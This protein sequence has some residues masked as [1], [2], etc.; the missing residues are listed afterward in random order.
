[1]SVCRLTEKFSAQ[2]CGV[3]TGQVLVGDCLAPNSY[4]RREKLLMMSQLYHCEKPG[5]HF[6]VGWFVSSYTFTFWQSDFNTNITTEWRAVTLWRWDHFTPR[7]AQGKTSPA[8]E[9]SD[10]RTDT[11]YWPVPLPHR[12]IRFYHFSLSECRGWA[13]SGGWSSPAQTAGRCWGATSGSRSCP[14]TVWW[15]GSQW[16]MKD[17]RWAMESSVPAGA[18]T[19]GNWER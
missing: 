7:V 2:G 17:S 1:M 8:W 16:N 12:D 13:S 10:T 3:T 5:R 9:Q 11:Q 15:G 19:A 14:W 6:T 18:E 4:S